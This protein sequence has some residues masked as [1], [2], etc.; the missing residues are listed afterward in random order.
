MEP[1]RERWI[2]R[3][4]AHL[5]SAAWAS[6]RRERLEHARWQCERC[7]RDGVPLE[8]HHV[9]YARLGREDLADL[10]AL[11]ETC[12]AEVHHRLPAQALLP[13]SAKRPSGGDFN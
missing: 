1:W 4:E 3:Y 8:V 9:T 13:F 11:C 6:I 2:A 10:W 12:H 7:R 5:Q